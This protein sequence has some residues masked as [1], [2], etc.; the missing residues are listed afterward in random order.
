MNLPIDI[1]DKNPNTF[2][3]TPAELNLTPVTT[4]E[5]VKI[6]LITSPEGDTELIPVG[7]TSQK[8]IWIGKNASL[9]LLMGNANTTNRHEIQSLSFEDGRSS[10][11]T[12]ISY[13]KADACVSDPD[14]DNPTW[15]STM[16]QDTND[17]YFY[18][19]VTI[20]DAESVQAISSWN[21]DT[22]ITKGLRLPEG[23]TDFGKFVFA[24]THF[25]KEDA[26]DIGYHN[27]TDFRIFIPS[28]VTSFTIIG[29][30]SSSS[31]PSTSPHYGKWDY[32]EV[33]LS[34][35]ILYFGYL[36]ND[37]SYSI[38]RGETDDYDLDY[39]YSDDVEED[40]TILLDF[41]EE[42]P[43]DIVHIY[44]RNHTTVPSIDFVGNI[45]FP[46]VFH[47]NTSIEADFKQQ[48]SGTVRFSPSGSYPT[49]AYDPISVVADVGER[50]EIIE[51]NTVENTHFSSIALSGSYGDLKNNPIPD[52]PTTDGNYVLKVTVSSGEPTYTWVSA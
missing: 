22:V 19:S 3:Y 40:P 7:N 15:G 51:G 16:Y 23:I 28:T 37:T 24:H 45:Y 42:N 21:K 52:A 9:T 36:M 33:P 26:Q 8:T 48:Y 46:I 12:N 4:T 29:E 5:A 38:W 35:N 47:V 6:P 1:T 27:P 18:D 20:S 49:S 43:H 39:P 25:D 14:W 44:L 11:L 50:P 17:N 10:V 41:L 30:N 32:V 2:S 34:S 13:G 31:V